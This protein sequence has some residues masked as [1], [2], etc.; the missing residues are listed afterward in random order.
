VPITGID[1]VVIR[2]RDLARLMVFYRDA[3]GCRVEWERPDLGLVHLRVGASLIDLVDIAGPLGD[4]GGAP[5]ASTRNMDHLCLRAEPF[6]PEAIA[7]R[8]V[9]AGGWAEPAKR[10]YGA[11]GFGPSVYLADPEGNRIEIKGPSEPGSG[12]APAQE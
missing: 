3:L 10:R 7:R 5:A 9:A 8:V 2:A 6:E 4:G 12:R 11:E 1:H